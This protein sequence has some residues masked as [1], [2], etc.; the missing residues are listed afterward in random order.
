MSRRSAFPAFFSRAEIP[1]PHFRKYRCL[2]LPFTVSVCWRSSVHSLKPPWSTK[3]RRI[4]REPT[5]LWCVSPAPLGS[6]TVIPPGIG[7][8]DKF[9]HVLEQLAEGHLAGLID[10]VV[11]QG[12]PPE[13]RVFAEQDA[14][15]ACQ[16]FFCRVDWFQPMFSTSVP[17]AP[18]LAIVVKAPEIMSS[19]KERNV[20]LRINISWFKNGKILK[21][22]LVSELCTSRTSSK[23]QI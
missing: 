9:P 1:W 22:R 7:V 4:S 18:R 17:V 10:G 14:V 20:R 19:W 16:P 13:E 12:S 15:D 3:T 8:L 23:C 2:F 5:W 6:Y 11:E 21:L